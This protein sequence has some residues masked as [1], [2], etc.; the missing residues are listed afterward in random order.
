MCGVERLSQQEIRVTANQG[1]EPMIDLGLQRATKVEFVG[2]SES[3][4]EVV[5]HGDVRATDRNNAIYLNKESIISRSTYPDTSHFPL[6]LKV[7]D[8]D[9]RV[10]IHREELSAITTKPTRAEPDLDDAAIPTPALEES[11]T[12]ANNIGP[13]ISASI[14]GGL[15]LTTIIGGSSIP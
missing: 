1:D 5:A 7:R 2:S 4:S 8:K 6:N 14:L 10:E 11:N 9:I 13:L 3:I 15:G 12:I